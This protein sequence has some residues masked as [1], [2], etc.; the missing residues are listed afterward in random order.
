MRTR[1][2]RRHRDPSRWIRPRPLWRRPARITA[3]TAVVLLALT[4]AGCG[5]G[6]A[7][8]RSEAESL[9]TA[10]ADEMA[11]VTTVRLHLTVDGD[12]LDMPVRAVDAVVTA[13]GD[14]AG[15]LT[16]TELG[17]VLEAEVR[18]VGD[19]LHY[20]LL[21][22]WQ[23]GTREE[24][25]RL[26]DVSAI[27]DP[28]RGV[29]QL[30]RTAELVA[31]DGTERVDGV[32]TQ[33]LRVRFA[34]AAVTTLLPGVDLPDP[35]GTVWIGAERPLLHRVVMDLPDGHAE[36]TLSRFDEPVDIRAP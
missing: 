25:A 29:A 2:L 6:P 35:V 17:Q 33:R 19:V 22:G 5:D 15:T 9:L 11:T 1:G 7:L 23:T 34:P 13:D 20:R 10:A 24:A 12:A 3:L 36:V 31:A 4:G 30:L 8:D 26:Y 18:L 32:S 28:D 14:A 16:V 27:L 21:G